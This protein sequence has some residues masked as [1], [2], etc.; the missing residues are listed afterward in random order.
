[1]SEKSTESTWKLTK[2]ARHVTQTLDEPGA[3]SSKSDKDWEVT[4][5]HNYMYCIRLSDSSLNA[6]WRL[7]FI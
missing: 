4:K 7:S 1:M 6:D 3:K 2:Y 5:L